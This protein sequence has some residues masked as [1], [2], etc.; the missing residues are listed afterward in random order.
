MT[1]NPFRLCK[2][3]S[4][5]FDICF[6]SFGAIGALALLE[7]E[8]KAVFELFA[9]S[10]LDLVVLVVRCYLAVE[11]AADA[12]V[13]AVVVLIVVADF[14]IEFVRFVWLGEFA[15]LNS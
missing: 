13:V 7:A 11:F 15:S 10:E 6:L 4:A 8:V 3:R 5:Y 1:G 12:T 2:F 9:Q 14:A